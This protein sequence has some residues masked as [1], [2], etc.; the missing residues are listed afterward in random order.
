MRAGWPLIPRVLNTAQ[1]EVAKCSKAVVEGRTFA[2]QPAG[3]QLISTSLMDKR[4]HEYLP[5]F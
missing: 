3:M 1:L 5:L 2:Y 4:K